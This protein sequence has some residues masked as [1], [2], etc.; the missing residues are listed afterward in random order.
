MP[1]GWLGLE[2]PPGLKD[3]RSQITWRDEQPLF[4]WEEGR[5]QEQPVRGQA[6]GEERLPEFPPETSFPDQAGKLAR[7][8]K[9]WGHCDLQD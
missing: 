6:W 3:R 9:E 7:G 5:K 8:P 2:F 1:S 4:S